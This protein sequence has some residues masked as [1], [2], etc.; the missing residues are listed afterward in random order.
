MENLQIFFLRERLW[1]YSN[2]TITMMNIV[3][4]QNQK[5]T[6]CF[7]SVHLVPFGIS[8]SKIQ[9][10]EPYFKWEKDYVFLIS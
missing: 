1:L 10:I 7:Y 2:K 9:E 8:K 6:G 5:K 3:E 4:N